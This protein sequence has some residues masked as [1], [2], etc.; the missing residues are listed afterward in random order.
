MIFFMNLLYFF[1][2][3]HVEIVLGR[4]NYLAVVLAMTNSFESFDNNFL[5][6]ELFNENFGKILALN[7]LRDEEHHMLINFRSVVKVSLKILLEGFVD[8]DLNVISRNLK[9]FHFR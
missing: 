6:F 1:I 5:N 8:E 4:L 2:H 9:F 3:H 7:M